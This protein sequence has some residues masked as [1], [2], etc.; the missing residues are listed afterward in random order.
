MTDALA[1]AEAAL[2]KGD[3]VAA[4]DALLDAWRLC[5]AREIAQVIDVVSDDL[6]RTLAAIDP[7]AKDFHA[8][9][10]RV[11]K[12]ARAC[13][14]PRLLPGLWSDPMSTLGLRLERILSRGEDPRTGRA[15]LTM[16]ERIPTRSS[17]GSG[18]TRA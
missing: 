4:L 18:S 12:D 9:W 14:A 11:E 15:F 3:R 8:D 16:I 13:D 7:E 17:S 10:L 5:K 2:E 6:G 1:T